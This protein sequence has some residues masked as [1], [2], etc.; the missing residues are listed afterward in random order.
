MSF[1][2]PD[3][4]SSDTYDKRERNLLCFDDQ[5]SKSSRTRRGFI[6]AYDVVFGFLNEKSFLFTQWP[7]KD[8][9]KF[10]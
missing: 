3:N 4:Y 2:L 9:T 1:F 8:K 5:D 6:T 7:V 10:A